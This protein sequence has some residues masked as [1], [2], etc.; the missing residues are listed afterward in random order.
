MASP[1]RAPRALFCDTNVL[2]RLLAD[3]PPG[4][5]KAV[6]SALE[7]AGNGRFAV[8]VTDVVLAEISYVLTGAYGRSRGDAAGLMR[9]ILELPGVEVA[10]P[11]LARET[12]D[13]WTSGTMDFADAYLAALGRTTKGTGILSF[14]RDLDKIEGVQRVDPRAI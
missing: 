12:L 2:I 7:V 6:Q 10:D 1:R 14:D 4:H 3:D 11:S 8:I 9:G 13:L 5:A